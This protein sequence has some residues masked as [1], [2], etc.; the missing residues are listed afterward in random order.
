MRRSAEQVALSRPGIVVSMPDS[1]ML[2]VV[3][4]GDAQTDVAVG[5]SVRVRRTFALDNVGQTFGVNLHVLMRWQTDEKFDRTEDGLVGPGYGWEPEWKPR[6]IVKNVMEEIAN[7]T[8]FALEANPLR[9]QTGQKQN[10]CFCESK[11]VVRCY[12]AMDPR[13]F[14]F[15]VQK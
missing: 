8:F 5:I 9:G 3:P 13:S 1:Q 14:P 6:W 15:D 10:I 7:Y 12:N 4:A 11:S 2:P